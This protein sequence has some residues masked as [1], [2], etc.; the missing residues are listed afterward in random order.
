VALSDDGRLIWEYKAPGNIRSPSIDEDGNLYC[1]GS[2]LVMYALDEDGKEKWVFKP[3]GDL[4]LYEGL[5]SWQNTLAMPSI[6][7]DGTIYAGSF[8]MPT[9]IT[10]TGQIIPNYSIPTP[11]KLYAITPKGQKKWEYSRPETNSI[12]KTPSIG[13]DG[14]LYAGTSCWKVLALKPEDGSIIWEFDTIEK[15]NECPSVYSP[16]IG[17]K[18][19]LLYAATTNARIFC[20]TPDGKEQW[21]YSAGNPWL[22]GPE[23]QPMMGGSNNFTPPPIGD[24][25][26]LYSVLAEGKVFSFKSTSGSDTG[27]TP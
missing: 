10:T 26:A 25:G 8:I 22:Q 4:P 12:L 16:T 21:Q 6:G 24:D 17:K 5:I 15:T 27:G 14:T 20:I 1:G 18:D 9:G 7:D 19:G 2:T 3:E 11:G 23:G 13:K